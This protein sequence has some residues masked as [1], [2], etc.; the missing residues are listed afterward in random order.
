MW[1]VG[2]GATTVAIGTY[3]VVL[4]ALGG[5]EKDLELDEYGRRMQDL[6]LVAP[7]GQKGI[8]Y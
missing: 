4:H 3:A 5:M 8:G 1:A 2:K 6:K 7:N